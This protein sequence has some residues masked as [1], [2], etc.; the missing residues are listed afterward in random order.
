M[1]ITNK[2]KKLPQQHRFLSIN[3]FTTN[4]N[5]IRQSILETNRISINKPIINNTIKNPRRP[6][7]TRKPLKIPKFPPN[8]QK[9]QKTLIPNRAIFH[10][11]RKFSKILKPTKKI[12]PKKL[13]NI[14][15]LLKKFN[16]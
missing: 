5:T 13:T 8:Q 1:L 4:T 10:F 12:F 11:S 15:K 16:K 2:T 3:K 14:L 7:T 6:K 9:L